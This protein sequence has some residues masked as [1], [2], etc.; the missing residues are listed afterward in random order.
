MLQQDVRDCIKACQNCF[1]V[2]ENCA[3]ECLREGGIEMTRCIELNLVCGDIC[4]YTE[5]ELARR[6]DSAKRIALICAEICDVCSEECNKHPLLDHCAACAKECAEC[7]ECC[8]QV[9]GATNFHPAEAAT[10]D[11]AI[12]ELIQ[13]AR[14][15]SCGLMQSQPMC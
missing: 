9:A 10:Y 2:C 8:L 15:Q 3:K 12:V 11:Q 13:S 4:A 14:K 6:P 7:A 1:K 5:R